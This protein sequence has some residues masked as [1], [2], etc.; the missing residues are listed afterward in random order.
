MHL[1]DKLDQAGLGEIAANKGLQQWTNTCTEGP[2]VSDLFL[3]PTQT[4]QRRRNSDKKERE[5]RRGGMR[6]R[7]ISGKEYSLPFLPKSLL[8]N[9]D[10]RKKN[11]Y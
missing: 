5:E 3:L 10:G 8:A 7:V 4:C 1:F 11:Q 2:F 9:T 6:G